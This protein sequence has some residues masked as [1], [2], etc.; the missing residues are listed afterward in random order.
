MGYRGS[1]DRGLR[2]DATLLATTW[3]VEEPLVVDSRPISERDRSM[4]G[5]FQPQRFVSATCFVEARK[6]PPFVGMTALALRPIGAFR[7]SATIA[8]ARTSGTF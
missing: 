1:S 7:R 3:C 8:P 6:G 5:S 4:A 2:F